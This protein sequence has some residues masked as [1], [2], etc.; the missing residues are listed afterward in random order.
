MDLGSGGIYSTAL[1]TCEFGSTF[2]K[3]YNR[4]LSEGSKNEMATLR[5]STTDASGNLKYDPD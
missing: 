5:S 4:L 1:D 3:G 2:F